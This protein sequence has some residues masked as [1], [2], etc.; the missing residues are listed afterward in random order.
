VELLREGAKDLGLTLFPRHLT[1]F[2]TYY[3]EL[4]SWNRRFNLTTITGYEEVQCKHFLD[5]LSCLLA[6]PQEHMT[7]AIPDTVPLQLGARQLWCLDVGSGAGFPG[8]P[9][10]IMLPEA[11]MTLV[12]ATSKKVTFLRHMVE[13]LGLKDV[14]VVH[15]R[16][17]DVGHM[18]Q[19]RERYDLVAVRAVAHLAVLA[20]Y[21]LP[22]C[23][24]GGRLV[25]QKGED[26]EEEAR[27]AQ[28]AFAEV[29]GALVDIK[30]VLLPGLQ[31][32]H[33]LVVLDKVAKTPEA[34]PRRAGVPSKRPIC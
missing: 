30:P 23:R 24:L 3:R 1:A 13:V 22:L 6:L 12:E 31:S 11:K 34:Y 14:E 33:Y 5:S 28:R 26:I 17:E 27:L 25:A 20:E 8:L 9:L 19:H 2:E 10:K 16:V 18:P 15:A 29:G 32:K 21:C 4:E 7:G